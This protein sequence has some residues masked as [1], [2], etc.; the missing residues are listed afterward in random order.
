MRDKA[1]GWAQALARGI[2]LEK[3]PSN[4]TREAGQPGSLLYCNPRWLPIKTARGL[5]QRHHICKCFIHKRV[6]RINE[7]IKI[8]VHILGAFSP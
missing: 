7:T 8:N 5:T 6:T 4:F 1:K 3:I 2:M